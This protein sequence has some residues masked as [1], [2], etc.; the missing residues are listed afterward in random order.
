MKIRIGRLLLFV[1]VLQPALVAQYRGNERPG[2]P[3]SALTGNLRFDLLRLQERVTENRNETEKK[4]PLTAA[5][6][7]A[8]LPGAGEFYVGDYWRATAFLTA[9]AALWV[10]YALY[11][12]RG[13]RQTSLFEQFADDHFSVVKYAE[14][15]MQYA[16]QL[17]P[18]IN[19]SDCQGIVTSSN[20]QLKP[21][22]R[23]DWS[24]LNRCEEAIG[25]KSGTG[26]THRLPLRPEQQYYELIGKYEQYNSGWDD[27]DV[28]ASNYLTKISSNFLKY[29]DMR[30]QANDFYNI[31]TT[32]SYLLVINHVFSALDAAFLAAQHNKHLS[33]KAH[34]QPTQR[35]YGMIE[36]VP[37]ASLQVGF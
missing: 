15:I 19:P 29:R 11:D 36:F 27:A 9:E 30:G 14:W 37:T 24:K 4:S 1:L 26:F 31:A 13:D 10:T 12:A 25:A 21:W 8:V 5:L 18:T 33:F 6:Y 32:F 16:M 34:L 28:D 35:P 3:H 20:T 2:E 23:I 22:E 17:N 7:S